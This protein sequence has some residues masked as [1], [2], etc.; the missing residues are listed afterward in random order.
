MNQ[1]R[2]HILDA[3]GGVDLSACNDPDTLFHTIMEQRGHYRVD[4]LRF[5]G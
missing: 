3:L 5:A 4:S 2:A 1:I